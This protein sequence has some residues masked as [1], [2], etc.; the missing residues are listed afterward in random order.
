MATLANPSKID[1]A[2][3][4]RLRELHALS[5]DEQAERLKLTR[6]QVMRLRSTLIQLGEL[7]SKRRSLAADGPERIR[8]LLAQGLRLKDVAARMELPYERLLRL[9]REH[10]IDVPVVERWTVEELVVMLGVTNDLIRFWIERG[11]LHTRDTTEERGVRK[12]YRVITRQELQQFLHERDAWPTYEPRLFQDQALRE[13]GEALRRYA[14]G[15]WVS[16]KELA[17][18]AGIKACSLNSRLE[19]GWLADWRWVHLRRSQFVWVPDG[20][21]LPEPTGDR[22]STR[23][24]KYG[25]NGLSPEV[26]ARR[27]GRSQATAAD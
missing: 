18:M 8:R 7:P 27:A 4:K 16:R 23:R 6:S 26:L 3:R 5:I 15:R 9:M 12:R 21:T 10:G 20:A 14:G 25:P 17:L 24:A 19:T 22:W 11:W 2:L 1:K 13:L